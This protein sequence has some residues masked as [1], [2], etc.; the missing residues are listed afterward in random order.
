[1][2]EF[3]DVTPAM[4]GKGL[5]FLALALLGV[6]FHAL[7][8][9]AKSETKSFSGW[10]TDNPKN[11]IM[12]FLSLVGATATITFNHQ[13]DNLSF[14]QLALMAFPVGYSIDSL[15]NKVRTK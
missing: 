7:K 6:V 3:F 5:V 13:L 10:F 1:M 12:A 9:W 8:K 15:V 2:E 4:A 11:T 14:T